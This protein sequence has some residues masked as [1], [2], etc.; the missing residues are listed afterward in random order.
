[1]QEDG[2]RDYVSYR[3]P[4][5]IEEECTYVNEYLVTKGMGA[6]LAGG[7]TYVNDTIP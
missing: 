2:R 3:N 1:M 7:E 5:G 6:E 4:A